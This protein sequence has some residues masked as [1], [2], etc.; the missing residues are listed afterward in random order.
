MNENLRLIEKITDRVIYGGGTSWNMDIQR[1]DW[2]PGVGLYG[3][4]KAWEATRQEKYLNFLKAWCERH[5]KEAYAQ[6]T[7]NSTAPLLTVLAVWQ[8]TCLLYTSDAADE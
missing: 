3:I 8:E 7:V 4:W 5:L 2:V 6:K 1:F